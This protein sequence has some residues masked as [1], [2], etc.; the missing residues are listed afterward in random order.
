MGAAHDGMK[1]CHACSEEGWITSEGTFQ[2]YA[3]RCFHHP[4]HRTQVTDD[5]L[6][7]RQDAVVE[8]AHLGRAH[9]TQSC[10]HEGS[11]L[12][13][14]TTSKNHGSHHSSHLINGLRVTFAIQSLNL[15]SPRTKGAGRELIIFLKLPH[16]ICGCSGLQHSLE[17]DLLGIKTATIEVGTPFVHFQKANKAIRHPFKGIASDQML[18]VLLFSV[19]GK[20]MDLLS[21]INDVCLQGNKTFCGWDVPGKL[22]SSEGGTSSLHDAFSKITR[23]DLNIISSLQ[24]V[25]DVIKQHSCLT[26]NL[27]HRHPKCLG[28]AAEI[29]VTF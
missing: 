26:C 16:D 19:V 23:S 29:N 17:V 2:C 8:D 11:S 4:I 20:L 28:D 21:R 24:C 25:G 10:S 14:I 18:H 12:G 15:S 3:G 1:A 22:V 9:A 13:R 7:S 6:G 5:G 27:I